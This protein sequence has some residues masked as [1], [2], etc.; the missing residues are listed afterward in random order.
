MSVVF[1]WPD[2]RKGNPYQKS[3]YSGF[4]TGTTTCG[5]LRKAIAAL[6]A[7]SS[8]NIFFHNHWTHWLFKDAQSDEQFKAVTSDFLRSLDKFRDQGGIFLWTVHNAG[9][10]ES[11]FIELE[12]N[13]H[14]ELA[15]RA[16]LVLLHEPN[17]VSIVRKEFRLVESRV[18]ILPHGNYL[19]CYAN[20]STKWDARKKLDIPADKPVFGFVGM[21]RPYKGLEEFVQAIGLAHRKNTEINAFIAGK[22][23][24]PLLSGDIERLAGEIS[25]LSVYEGFIPDD[26]LH[27]YLNAADF[28]VLPYRKI[29]TSGSVLLA[30]SFARPVLLPR[31]ESFEGLFGLPFVFTY[32]PEDVDDMAAKVLELGDLDSAELE[33][34]SQAALDWAKTRDWKAISKQL[35]EYLDEVKQVREL[36]E[37]HISEGGIDHRVQVYSQEDNG[38]LYDIALCV[39]NYRSIGDLRKLQRSLQ[40][41]VKVRWRMLVLDN[42]EEE[43][44]F[45]HLK[46]EFPDAV[47]VKPEENLGY[48]AGNNVL[49]AMAKKAG[50]PVIGILNPDV[51]LAKDCIS[52]MVDVVLSSPG[53]IHSP[54][55]AKRNKSGK[56]VVSF[57]VSKISSENGALKL[58]HLH[59]GVPTSELGDIAMETDSLSG[60]AMF[61]ASEIIDEYGYIPEQYFLY[62]EE[63]DWTYR[64][65]LKGV[66]L[67]VHTDVFI[68][69]SKASQKNGVPTLSYAYYLLRGAILF[70]ENFGFDINAT[71]KYYRRT[72]V[73][74][75][76]A[77]LEKKSKA[78][79]L[80]FLQV[81]D[82]AFEDGIKK[83]GGVIDIPA[84][85]S[86]K[87]E[88]N[89]FHKSLGFLETVD[90]KKITGWAGGKT[91]LWPRVQLLAVF[92]GDQFVGEVA[93][94]RYRED[95]K[96]LGFKAEAG[97]CFNFPAGVTVSK[98]GVT[99]VNA[100]T[101]VSLETTDQFA[102]QLKLL[103]RRL[104]T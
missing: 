42:S 79:Q 27:Y 90:S 32:E 50:F 52:K 77:K 36:V 46:N 71:E 103:N 48:A 44:E 65:K 87:G 98:N 59:K 57:L 5:P 8:K 85:L 68:V 83:V 30:A 82:L 76:A 62:F 69:H 96:K 94:E 78:F 70:A 40:K 86:K 20:T 12:R 25:G 28:I 92:N 16:D 11:K 3:L 31:L 45:A 67:L 34:L 84:R 61:F 93:P 41:H 49:M 60:C 81:S 18:R 64:M 38:Q 102:E 47:L 2:Y 72:F 1:F 75:W 10:H 15:R 39:V 88:R 9:N 7:D 99:V 24:S 4:P 35:N 6:Q 55:I 63:T 21:L 53:A 33:R 22:P 13:F 97:F 56:K 54:V 29:L 66:P 104:K 23:L 101:G 73:R 100:R 95:V 37:V 89:R 19:G 80:V 26:E 91:W 58:E 51:W 74:H 14:E 17:S 43:T